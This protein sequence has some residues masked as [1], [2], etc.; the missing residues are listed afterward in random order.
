MSISN[1][2]TDPYA[3]QAGHMA[4]SNAAQAKAAKFKELTGKE[5]V[6]E[7]NSDGEFIHMLHPEST[8][9][10]GFMAEF[11]R[12]GFNSPDGFEATIENLAR[13]YAELRDELIAR[14]G[15]NQDKLYEQLGQLNHAF[16][17]ALHST[18]LLPLQDRSVMVLSAAICPRVIQDDIEREWYEHEQTTA[19]MQTLK[20]NMARH[21]DA[22]F[23][24]FIK[25]IQTAD[26]DVAFANAI[27][28]LTE[29][30]A[31]TIYTQMLTQGM[32]NGTGNGNPDIVGSPIQRLNA[33][34]FNISIT[35]GEIFAQSGTNSIALQNEFKDMVFSL[36]DDAVMELHGNTEDA[37]KL[38][39]LRAEGR[40]LAETFLNR[41]FDSIR[42]ITPQNLLDTGMTLSELAFHESWNYMYFEVG[43]EVLGGTPVLADAT[44]PQ[45][46]GLDGKPITFQTE[47]EFRR[48]MI[49]TLLQAARDNAEIHSQWAEMKAEEAERWRKAMRIAARIAAGHNVPMRDRQFLMKVSPGMY[50][51]ANASRVERDNPRDYDSVLSDDDESNGDGDGG[52]VAAAVG[53]EK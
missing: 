15:D 9:K 24:A 28:K 47:A 48:L 41:F 1:I 18:I 19:L 13:R 44:T 31:P 6:I 38:E 51:I 4:L 22:F 37:H 29:L 30:D 14:H 53:V 32:N 7:K 26:F 21:L 2:S 34:L 3:A 16:E 12:V 23:E 49:E 42:S 10:L 35:F 46:I 17:N 25:N 39:Q 36:F 52:S 45:H 50:M 11:F 8:Q 5:I 33:M 40:N 43:T 20:Q 27:T